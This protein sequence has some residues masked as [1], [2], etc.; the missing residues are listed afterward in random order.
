MV[1][2]TETTIQRWGDCDLKGTN[3][4]QMDGERQMRQNLLYLL[5]LPQF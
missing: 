3:D 4:G 2:Q 5:V 1:G